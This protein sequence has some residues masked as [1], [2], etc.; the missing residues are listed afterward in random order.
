ATDVSI[1]QISKFIKEGRISLLNAPNLAYPCDVC[2]I[3]IREGSI[4]DSCRK[5]LTKDVNAVKEEEDRR[6][7]EGLAQ[8]ESMTY[9]AFAKKNNE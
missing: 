3:L 6:R 8:R 5:R 7:R 9:K 2:G 4:C 1:K